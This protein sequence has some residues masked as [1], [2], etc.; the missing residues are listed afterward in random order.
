[1]NLTPYIVISPVRNEAEHLPLTIRSMA[2]QTIRP[3]KWVIVNDGST[4]QTRQIAEE[5]A[6]TYPW[7]TVVNR[8]DRG[9]RKAGS[10]VVDAF[11]AGFQLV[12][13]LQYDF[14][15]KL[16]GDMSFA[17]DYFSDCF[18]RFTDSSRL[19][20]AGGTVY[21]FSNGRPVVE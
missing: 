8:S 19:G 6:K 3:T 14:L 10:G 9:Y 20:I 4:D 21:I 12:E 11:Y 2:A 7:I 1:M 15:V 16:D 18:R 13:Q 5:A 17:P